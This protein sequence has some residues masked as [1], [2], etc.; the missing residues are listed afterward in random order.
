M[1]NQAGFDARWHCIARDVISSV[2]MR[3]VMPPRKGKVT[4][5]ATVAL[6]LEYEA[7]CLL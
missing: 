6:A 5:L 1:T 4:L 2:N 7:A 3:M